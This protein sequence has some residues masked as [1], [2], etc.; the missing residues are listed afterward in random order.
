M[1]NT[2]AVSREECVR[3]DADDPLAGFRDEFELPPGVIY[4]DGNSLG[5]R[6]RSASEVSRR[7]VEDEWG[8]GLI[9]SW[10]TANWF[11]LPGRLG[12]QLSVIIGGGSGETVVTDTTSLNL[13]KVL[14]AAL[15]I[16]EVDHPGRR[17]IVS[18][19]DNFPTDLYIAE[20]LIALLDRGYELR[21]VDDDH[22][23]DD[24]LGPE[25]AAVMLS[26]VNYRTGALWD[27]VGISARPMIT[28]R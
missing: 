14:A 5:A 11:S 10:N 2:G 9:R 15:R 7:V 6:P 12:D 17:V 16:A 19:R 25:V 27:L 23:L 21:L 1:I 8:A 24:L 20:G 3:R 18:E 13:F 22:D 4:L 26:Q 28:A